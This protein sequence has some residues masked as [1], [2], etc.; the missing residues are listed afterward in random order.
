MTAMTY[1]TL[2]LGFKLSP[3]ALSQLQKT[4]HT[5]HYHPDSKIPQDAWK[6][7]DVCFA[8]PRGLP[9]DLKLG[10]VPNLRLLQILS[11]KSYAYCRSRSPYG[12]VD[13]GTRQTKSMRS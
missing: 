4:F 3:T 7:A 5:V 10:D 13:G 11:G 9:D 6:E 1:S 2:V 8:G 12:G